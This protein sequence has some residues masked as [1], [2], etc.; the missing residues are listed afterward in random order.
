MCLVVW[1]VVGW[2]IPT[3]WSAK[4][5]ARHGGELVCTFLDVGHGSSVLLQLPDGKNVLYDSGSLGSP[6][7]G[8]RSIAG[9]LWYQGVQHIDAV[10]ISHAD[11]DHF[12]ALPQLA[13][14]FTIGQV[15]VSRMMLKDRSLQVRELLS[16]LE[17]SGIEVVSV[18]S[19]DRLFKSSL[20]S[21]DILSPLVRAFVE[22]TMP[23]VS[24]GWSSMVGSVFYCP[25]ISRRKDWCNCWLA[26]LLR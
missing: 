25:V 5:C 14:Q 20:V 2:L 26:I 13:K 12:N 11:A 1:L 15:Y 7:S 10:V 23:I 21:F 4:E 22:T 6:D 3:R 17:E 24:Y 9:A 19:G 8:A 16:C 18:A